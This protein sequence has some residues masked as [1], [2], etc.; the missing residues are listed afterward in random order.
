M[1]RRSRNKILFQSS[2][3]NT[4][5]KI[6]KLDE[7]NYVLKSGILSKRSQTTISLWKP[8]WIVLRPSYI[9]Y[10]K[11]AVD[12]KALGKLNIETIKSVSIENGLGDSTQSYCFA[13]NTFSKK[14]A[15]ILSAST[16]NECEEWMTMFLFFI[17]FLFNLI[18]FIF[19]YFIYLFIYLL[20]IILF[21]IIYY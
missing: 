20:F 13:I 18:Y 15:L 3:V 16:L 5:E 21:I 2:D 19:N 1:A 9:T 10:F 14:H 17:Y 8:L 4:D 6:K 7:Q 11:S 12:K